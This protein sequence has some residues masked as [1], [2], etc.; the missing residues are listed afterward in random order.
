[1]QSD[2][3][4]TRVRKDISSSASQFTRSLFFG[5]A[6]RFE[7]EAND[8]TQKSNGFDV[9][10]F[11]HAPDRRQ[12]A[13]PTPSEFLSGEVLIHSDSIP[14]RTVLACILT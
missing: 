1:M 11:L 8:S 9:S 7:I 10:A 6:D 14:I 5:F 2:L 3:D 13:F 4:R 12:G